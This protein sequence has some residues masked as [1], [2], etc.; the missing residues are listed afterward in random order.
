MIHFCTVQQS[1]QFRITWQTQQ[2][3]DYL[4]ICKLTD[5]LRINNYRG[6]VVVHE[7]SALVLFLIFAIMRLKKLNELYLIFDIHDALHRKR[8]SWKKYPKYF[9]YL[10][11]EI[12]FT[13]IVPTYKI[14]VVSD[15]QKEVLG[16]HFKESRIFVVSNFGGLLFDH[17]KLQKRAREVHLPTARYCYF[18]YIDHRKI[19]YEFYTKLGKRYD[20]K[21]YGSIRASLPD[22]LTPC[23]LGAYTQTDYNKL[24]D[25]FDVL[26]YIPGRTLIE[27]T[28]TYLNVK[29]LMALAAG[30]HVIVPKSMSTFLSLFEHNEIRFLENN[31]CLVK[32][33]ENNYRFMVQETYD[34]RNQ[35]LRA[36]Y[37]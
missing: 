28:E 14:L 18:G 35:Y 9:L 29:L 21:L 12:I 8:F 15:T 3:K 16:K 20:L 4:I 27:I 2:D 31:L 25:K 36:C 17:A 30:K 24:L 26:I 19:D 33:T 23:W 7:H 1:K 13:K 10:A 5:L 37:D 22:N 32:L 34:S 11:A 6:T